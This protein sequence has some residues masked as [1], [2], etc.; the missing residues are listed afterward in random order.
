MTTEAEEAVGSRYQAAT[1][2]YTA[3]WEDL[4]CYFSH[5]TIPYGIQLLKTSLGTA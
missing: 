4:T 3:N 1:G 5:F 2:K